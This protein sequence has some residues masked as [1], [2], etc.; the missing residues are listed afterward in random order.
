MTGL[1]DVMAGLIEKSAAATEPG[2]FQR[3]GLWHCGKCGTARQCR[4]ELEGVE[5]VVWCD[6]RCRE[7]AHLAEQRA[8]RNQ[9]RAMKIANL[10]VQGIQDKA[11]RSFTFDRSWDKPFLRENIRK[12]RE[13]VEHWP[14]NLRQNLG[15]LMVGKPGRG[16]TYAAACI[17]NALIDKGVPVLVT[18]IPKIL[19][20]SGWD[21]AELTGQ[22]KEFDL[23]VLDDLGTERKERSGMTNGYALEIVQ[24]VIDE[25][26]KTKKPLIVTTNLSKEEMDHPANMDYW[27][28]F[29]RLGEM[30][31]APMFFD[32]PSLREEIRRDKLRL[33]REVFG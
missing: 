20:S 27:R 5:L 14:E 13:Y 15:L 11:M 17:A 18:S 3:D 12:C 26:Y 4:I 25:R 30:C 29:D 16:K 22:M 23:L 32:G 2:D 24:M 33:A 19:N 28:I 21:K 10:R 7:E 6:C 1:S 9:E 31:A 8:L